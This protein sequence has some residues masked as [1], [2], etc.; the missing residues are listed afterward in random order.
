MSLKTSQ[1]IS[2]KPSDVNWFMSP[3]VD[4]FININESGGLIING[5]K[6]SIKIRCFICDTPARSFF[7]GQLF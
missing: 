4:E 6:V 3:F 5:H 2:G 7:K 1:K